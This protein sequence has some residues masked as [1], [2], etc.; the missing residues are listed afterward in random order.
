MK[1]YI[2]FGPPGAGKGTQAKLLVEKFNLRHISTGDLLREQIAQQTPLGLEAK[3]LIDAGHLVP[4]SVVV[5]MIQTIFEKEDNHNGFLLDGFPRTIRQAEMLN[6]ILASMDE[7]VTK[8][9]SLMIEDSVIFQI[10][11]HRAK[12]EGRVDDTSDTIIQNRID[13]YHQKTEPLINFYKNEGN[14]IEIDGDK[15]VEEVFASLS[16]EIE[17]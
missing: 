3:K 16:E 4:D 15:S 11:Y 13:T 6:D 17:K 7:K 10:I 9:L 5:Q 1:Y 12:I 8:V 2:L 14:Y